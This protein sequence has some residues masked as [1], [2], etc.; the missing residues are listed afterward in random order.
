MGVFDV[1]NRTDSKTLVRSSNDRGGLVAL[2]LRPVKR[3]IDL[4]DVVA[5]DGQGRP[6]ESCETVDVGLRVPAVTGLAALA[7]AIDVHHE[8]QV[9]EFG[10]AGLFDRLPHR[11]LSHL[12][13]ATQ[14]PD[15]VV[16]PVELLCAQ[17]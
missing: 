11:A 12:A 14:A 17:A 10:K 5:V 1:I 7:E 4:T 6:A 9:V 8:R 3:G 15:T 13:I 2:F 16:Q